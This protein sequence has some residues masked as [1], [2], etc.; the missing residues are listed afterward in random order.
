MDAVKTEVVDERRRARE[1]IKLLM[2]DYRGGNVDRFYLNMTA[3][4]FPWPL[5]LK[6]FAKLT[7]VP[8]ETQD[9]FLVAWLEHKRPSFAVDNQPLL[10]AAARVMLSAYTSPAVR[11]FRGA[12]F[13]ESRRRSYGLSWTEDPTEAERFAKDCQ[14]WPGG[15]VVFETLA[16]SAAIIHKV[17]Y[18]EPVP[19]A[20]FEEFDHEKE[21]IVDGRQLKRVKIVRRFLEITPTEIQ[22]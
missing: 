3:G 21:Y 22:A 14:V 7:S 6:E 11:L 13:I 10:C 9:T 19:G 4:E 16:P 8:P 17:A 15:S 12:C 20:E 1:R 5:A 18:P 2:Q